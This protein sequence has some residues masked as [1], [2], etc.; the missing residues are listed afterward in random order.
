MSLL[1]LSI[2]FSSLI[3]DRH[4]A[5]RCSI[6]QLRYLAGSILAVLGS[7]ATVSA[8]SIYESLSFGHTSPL[9]S[10][11]QQI[12]SWHI[13]FE[14]PPPPILSDRVILTPPAPGSIRTGL[15]TDNALPGNSFTLDFAFRASGPERGSG[16]LQLW[17]VKEP[18]PASALRSVYTV[19]RFEGLAVVFDQYS[20]TGGSIRGFLNDGSV[21]YRNH[22]NVDSLAFGHCSYPFRN[23]GRWSDIRIKQDAGGFEVQ[24]EGKTCFQS[25]LI[26][27][28]S[29]YRF[30]ISAA[31]ADTPDSFEVS[32]FVVST[33]SQA[34]TQ[35][36]VPDGYQQQG[37]FQQQQQANFQT[38]PPSADASE[39]MN[40]IQSLSQ[41]LQS[42][43]RELAALGDQSLQRHNELKTSIG[44]IP[45]IPQAQIAA[46]DRRLQNIEAVVL[47]VQRDI[48]GRDYKD[49]LAGLQSSLRET[50][51]DLL[52]SLPQNMNKSM[53]DV[54]HVI[55]ILQTNAL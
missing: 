50:Q 15:W 39:L 52:T 12:T 34:P 9:S 28:P 35:R 45:A 26:S 24:V 37:S 1:L 13:G 38:P 25:S 22:H 41:N 23:L 47:R 48:E 44:S 36:Q 49:V 2:E 6:M 51:S 54:R 42:T 32:K 29:G 46:M 4:P 5:A 7:S 10:N 30:G 16:N 11:G 33:A 55:H 8:Q 20:G 43:Y 17:F 14:G 53:F 3:H 21:D 31:S 27:F 40:R 19:D 18:T